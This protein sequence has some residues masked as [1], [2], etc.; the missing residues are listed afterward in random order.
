MKVRLVGLFA[1]CCALVA[2]VCLG[3]PHP[4]FSQTTKA[5]L[6]NAEQDLLN[7]INQARANPQTYAGYL[8]KLKPM[9]RGKQ[10][11]PQGGTAFDTQEGWSAVEDAIKFLRTAKPIGPLT[12]STGLCLAAVSHVKD[13]SASGATGHQ[14]GDRT[15]IEDR[16][17]PYG[18]WQGGIG[19]N[20]AYGSQSARERLLMWLI[21]D[22]FATRGHRNRLMSDG[23]KVAG[24][25]C[26][27]HP[28]Y[29]TVCVLTLAGAFMETGNNAKSGAPGKTNSTTAT[30]TTATQTQSN[31]NTAKP[32]TG[33][34]K[35][36]SN[37]ANTNAKPRKL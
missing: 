6:S 37:Q 32:T 17:K 4:S 20:L 26:G 19:E 28:Q 23:Y 29:G 21:D 14:G 18:T 12:T 1:L 34:A 33:G 22:G 11:T 27:P 8:E 9:F 16:V 30:Q 15:M 31:A 7:E 24:V 10:Y 13:Q 2:I 3:G 36:N 5:N 35:T 25:S